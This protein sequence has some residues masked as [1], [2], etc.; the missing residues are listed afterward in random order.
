MVFGG[1]GIRLIWLGV[2]PRL[3]CRRV[4]P[5]PA[6]GRLVQFPVLA[7]A[8]QIKIMRRCEISL[9]EYLYRGWSAPVSRLVPLCE[10]RRL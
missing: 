7:T 6:R 9:I 1:V 3:L 2:S 5:P 10:V 4:L 8:S